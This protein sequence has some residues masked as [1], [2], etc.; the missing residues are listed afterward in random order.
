MR[1]KINE[2]TSLRAGE[3][4]KPSNSRDTRKFVVTVSGN[5]PETWKKED[6]VNAIKLGIIGSPLEIEEIKEAKA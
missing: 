2:T 6:I 1:E 4:S 3:N 5:I